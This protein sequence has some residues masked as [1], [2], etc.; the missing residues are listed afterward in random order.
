MSDILDH[1][2]VEI[3]RNGPYHLLCV[4]DEIF[5]TALSQEALLRKDRLET[6]E[7]IV[8][9]SALQPAAPEPF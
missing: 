2:D 8:E 1:E 9:M 7:R 6:I 4:K 5:F 3:K